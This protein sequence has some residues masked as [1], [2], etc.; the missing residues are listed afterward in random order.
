MSKSSKIYE[1]MPNNFPDDLADSLL[2]AFDLEGV[3]SREEMP[4][5]LENLYQKGYQIMIRPDLVLH[6]T[7]EVWFIRVF[8]NT[9]KK[10]YPSATWRL[11][12]RLTYYNF[13][14]INDLEAFRTMLAGY[15]QNIIV[16]EEPRVLTFA[17]DSVV[18]IRL[19]KI[20]L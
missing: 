13:R 1:L 2:A 16:K 12:N 18:D 19:M 15:S 8:A 20:K 6:P 3:D 9:D 17:I 7:Q 4:K 10:R 14:V 5:F 11:I